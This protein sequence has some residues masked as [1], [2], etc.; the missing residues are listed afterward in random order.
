[1][2]ALNRVHVERRGS[3]SV[4]MRSDG[5]SSGPCLAHSTVE[6][7]G[8]LRVSQLSGGTQRDEMAVPRDLRS[9]GADRCP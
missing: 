9:G 2:S 7:V 6:S 5:A 4:P 3:W 8:W 1:M